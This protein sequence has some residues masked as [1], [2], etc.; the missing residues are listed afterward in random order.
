MQRVLGFLNLIAT[1]ISREVLAPSM[2]GER[3]PFILFTVFTGVPRTE[4]PV[5]AGAV[6]ARKEGGAVDASLLWLPRLL[7]PHFD[8][9]R[10]FSFFFGRSPFL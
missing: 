1:R 5:G 3:G 7:T 9:V 10:R 2:A 6:D 4:V 8:L